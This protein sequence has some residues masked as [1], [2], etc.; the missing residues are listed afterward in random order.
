MLAFVR[1]H[2][3]AGPAEVYAH[4]GPSS[5]KNGWGRNSRASTQLLDAMHYRGLL[6]V[7]RRKGGGNGGGVAAAPR[8]ITL[9]RESRRAQ[10]G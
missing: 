10:P 5:E 3:L 4:F 8:G 2:G 6:R 9:G 1:E 7:A